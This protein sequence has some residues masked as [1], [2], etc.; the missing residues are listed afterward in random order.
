[1]TCHLLAPAPAVVSFETVRE[2]CSLASA[3]GLH[4]R[5]DG[6]LASGS[7]KERQGP[8]A[9][10]F[11]CFI[12]DHPLSTD[13]LAGVATRQ[14]CGLTPG[15]RGI[16]WVSQI[17]TSERFLDP[18]QGFGGHWRIRGNVIVAGDQQLM[19]RIEELYRNR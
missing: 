11:Q 18:D 15:W 1:L 8:Q 3:N 16:V 14:D 6:N 9:M 2:L 10:P 5:S 4:T 19:N 12:S 17:Q 7:T 13:D